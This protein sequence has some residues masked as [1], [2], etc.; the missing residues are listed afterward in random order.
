MRSICA[1]VKSSGGCSVENYPDQARILQAPGHC[2]V[3]TIDAKLQ[4]EKSQALIEAGADVIFLPAL[5][6]H[7][8]LQALVVELGKRGNQLMVEAEA[9]LAGAFIAEGLVDELVCYWAPKLFGD[10]AKTCIPAYPSRL[11][12]PIW[13]FPFRIFVRSWGGYQGGASPR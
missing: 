5:G 2:L 7:I 6:E 11:L 12:M 10:Q 4:R 13:P 1:S 3:A 9:G 8:D